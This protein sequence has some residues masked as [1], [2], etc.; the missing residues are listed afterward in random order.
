M[1]LFNLLVPLPVGLLK[2]I[3]QKSKGSFFVQGKRL[4]KK[5]ERLKAYVG[6]GGP[7]KS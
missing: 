3:C 7:G 1:R 4:N 5:D 6:L 2:G